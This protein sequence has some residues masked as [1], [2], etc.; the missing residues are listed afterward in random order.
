[1][2]DFTAFRLSL[3]ADPAFCLL[4]AKQTECETN[5]S[6]LSSTW[7]PDLSVVASP[8]Q[9]CRHWFQAQLGPITIFLVFSRLLRI[10]KLGL[11]LCERRGLTSTGNSSM[12]SDF[13]GSDLVAPV[14]VAV[15]HSLIRL[16]DVVF[17]QA[18]DFVP[19]QATSSC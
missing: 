9:Q 17:K 7:R 6:P 1:V 8:S 10:L 15:T 19:L 2:I 12:G 11:L 18:D 3:G 14:R 5:H 13:S 16:H 4:G